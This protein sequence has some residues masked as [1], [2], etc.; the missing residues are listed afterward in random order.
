[1]HVKSLQSCPTLCHPM[2]CSLPGSSVLGFSSKNTE[3]GC[4][5]LLQGIFPTQGSNLCLLCLLHWQTGSLP[6]VLPGKPKPH[7]SQCNCLI[8]FKMTSAFNKQHYEFRRVYS[9]FSKFV[10]QQSIK[11][12]KYFQGL[13]WWSSG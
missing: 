4:C 9:H 8:V 6:L 7:T 1:M 10:S 13:P 2:D 3:V 11:F 12:M 5:A